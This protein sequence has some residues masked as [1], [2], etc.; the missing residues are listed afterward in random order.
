MDLREIRYFVAVAQTGSFFAASQSLN[1]SQPAV[2]LQVKQLEEELGVQLLKR[3]SRGVTVTRPGILF[4]EQAH[5]ILGAVERAHP[6]LKPFRGVTAET[7]SIGASPTP[8]RLLVLELL[9]AV[10][11]RPDLQIEIREGSTKTLTADVAGGR[12]D[13]ALCYDFAPD[14]R[15]RVCTFY[16]EDLALVGPPD[17]VEGGGAPIDFIDLARFP[18]VVNANTNAG[19]QFVDRVAVDLGVTLNVVSEAEPANVKRELL[20]RHRRCSIVPYGLFIDDIDEG[21]LNARPIRRPSISLP[22][23]LLARKGFPDRRLQKVRELLQEIVDRIVAGKKFG[24][25]AAAP[26]PPLRVKRAAR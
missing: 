23:H 25:R 19:R 2:S 15:V 14:E 5:N 3:H 12:L 6:L 7:L 9:T 20:V 18:L 10:R 4:L 26:M 11:D 8:A 24:W 13:L 17:L 16:E 1:V 22:L 21:R